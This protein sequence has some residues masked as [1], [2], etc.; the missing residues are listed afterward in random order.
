MPASL[1][2]CTLSPMALASTASRT[3]TSTFSSIICCICSACLDELAS[4][5]AYLTL[6]WSRV[7][8]ATFAL[9]KG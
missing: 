3:M 4:A 5:L 9:K 1:A 2:F 7:R 6:P 8:S